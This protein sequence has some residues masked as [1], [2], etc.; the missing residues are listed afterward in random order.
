MQQSSSAA[1]WL[2]RVF[3]INLQTIAEKEPLCALYAIQSVA[4][5]VCCVQ[6]K[7]LFDSLTVSYYALELDNIGRSRNFA[8]LRK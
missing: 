1:Y 5:V 7:S 2:L 4:G 8:C 3:K 6:V